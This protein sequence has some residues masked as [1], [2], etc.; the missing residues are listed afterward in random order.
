MLLAFLLSCTD[1]AF[2]LFTEYCQDWTP[3]SEAYMTIE[4]TDAGFDVIR[5]GVEKPCDSIFGADIEIDGKVIL[6]HESWDEG[7]DDSCE[8][9]YSPTVAVKE[10]PRGNLTVRWFDDSGQATAVHA[11]EVDSDAVDARD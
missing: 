5:V 2:I 3:G 6:I 4:A 8:V 1:T 9:C 11:A 7:P 10:P